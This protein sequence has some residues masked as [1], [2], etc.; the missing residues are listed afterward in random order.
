MSLLIEKK[1]RVLQITLNRPQKRNALTS[2][3]CKGLIEA[4][5]SVQNDSEI[6]SVLIAAAGHVFCA[7]MDLEEAVSPAGMDLGP[8]HERLFV[9]GFHSIK[10]II[11][12]V[13]GAALGGGLGLVAQGHV[14]VAER[15]SV[16]ALPEIRIGLWPFLVYR[17]VENSIGSRRTLALS[18]TARSFDAEEALAWGL[19]HSICPDGEVREC[20]ANIAEEIAKGGLRAIQA[21]M[22]YVRDSRGKSLQEAGEIAGRLRDELMR[23]EDFRESVEAF[24]RKR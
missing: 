24:K 9:I 1:S 14:V 16:F 20:A 19:I 12:A 23:S 6:G 8:L 10:P 13:N 4:V 7:G 5:E 3:M 11:V 17:A 21:G 2:N 15:S 22:T 18:L